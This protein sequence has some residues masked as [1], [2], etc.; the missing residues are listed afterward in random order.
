MMPDI[1]MC[2]NLKCPSRKK[3]YRYRAIPN[4]GRQFYGSHVSKDKDLKCGFFLRI[5]KNDKLN[6]EE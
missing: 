3:C 2:R 1:S 5:M 4:D 6:D